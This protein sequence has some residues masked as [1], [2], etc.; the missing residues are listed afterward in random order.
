MEI[1]LRA[2]ADGHPSRYHLIGS[3]V[4][5]VELVDVGAIGFAG[6]HAVLNGKRGRLVHS[7][8][9]G[10]H[11][12]RAAAC[13]DR[14]IPSDSLMGIRYAIPTIPTHFRGES[15]RRGVRRGPNTKLPFDDRRYLCGL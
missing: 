14:H 10:Q 1:K 15:R 11:R 2:A 3:G 8:A 12:A 9:R 7:N 13:A 6:Q 5:G 4:V